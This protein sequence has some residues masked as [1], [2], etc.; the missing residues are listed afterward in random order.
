MRWRL[1]HRSKRRNQRDHANT[2]GIPTKKRNERIE[3]KLTRAQTGIIASQADLVGGS[4]S[5]LNAR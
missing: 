3:R 1:G 4:Q 2:R 5:G